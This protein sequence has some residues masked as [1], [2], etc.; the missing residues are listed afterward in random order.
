LT[1]LSVSAGLWLRVADAWPA[2]ADDLA[3]GALAES[4][5]FNLI[6]G[7]PAEPLPGVCGVAETVRSLDPAVR[8]GLVVT[9]Y[10]A[11]PAGQRCLAQQLADILDV[12]VRAK[13]GMTLVEADGRTCYVRAVGSAGQ[14]S[15][16]PF[17]LES[18]YCPGSVGGTLER[19]C[20]PFPG[21]VAVGAGSYRLTADWTVEVV[22]AG[23]SVHL[24]CAVA[25][26]ALRQAPTDPER[27]D[28]VVDS[29]DLERPP[30]EVVSALGRLADALATSA[31]A[32]M[33]VVLVCAGAL[34][35]ARELRLA[36]PAAQRVR[37][38]PRDLLFEPA[39]R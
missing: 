4:G 25:E 21:A 24:A 5:R 7:G 18:T 30:L 32:R 38:R 28:L 12:P 6:V 16:R 11:E 9:V 29:G 2:T 13:H 1:V 17:A 31:R 15:W 27:V 26:G 10:G 39:A 22:P 8:E 34:A 35:S 20:A 19:W 3:I 33:Q 14:G 37:V 23:L 36:V